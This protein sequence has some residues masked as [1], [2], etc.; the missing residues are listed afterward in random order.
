VTG[1]EASAAPGHHVLPDPPVRED[2]R[3]VVCLKPRRLTKQA[4]KYAGVW[5]DL[6][7]FCASKCCRK[8]HGCELPGDR[9]EAQEQAAL[10]AADHYRAVQQGW[11]A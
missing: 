3:C 7:P 9:T 8:W 6:D 1:R 2:G 5:L 10:D 4:R 11:V